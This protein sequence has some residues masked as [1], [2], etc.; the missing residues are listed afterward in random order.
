VIIFTF[1]R[2][3]SVSHNFVKIANKIMSL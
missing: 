3:D 2:K 1:G